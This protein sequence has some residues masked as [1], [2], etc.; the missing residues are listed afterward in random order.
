MKLG[1]RLAA[2]GLAA[3]MTLTLAACGGDVTPDE[4][5]A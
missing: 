3:V 4:A 2:A 5:K 1:K